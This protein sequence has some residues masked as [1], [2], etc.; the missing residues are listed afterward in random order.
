MNNSLGIKSDKGSDNPLGHAGAAWY[1]LKLKQTM[2]I[3]QEEQIKAIK[4]TIK[5][6]KGDV[7]KTTKAV[8]IECY[9][10]DVT[11]LLK[12]LAKAGQGLRISNKDSK[13]IAKLQKPSV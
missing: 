5:E 9:M 3:T 10:H 1:F 12:A 4:D 11:Y 2:K 13:A 6:L 7:S 8:I